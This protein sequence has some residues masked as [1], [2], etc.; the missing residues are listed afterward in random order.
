[1]KVIILSAGQGTRLL[2]LTAD[3]PKPMIPVAGRPR[4]RL[5]CRGL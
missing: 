1:M 5:A 4:S 3:R 2:P